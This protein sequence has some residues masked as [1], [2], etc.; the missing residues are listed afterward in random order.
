MI[1]S[2]DYPLM[3]V[4]QLARELNVPRDFVF[5]HVDE[6][7][8][9]CCVCGMPTRE[10]LAC[11]VDTS[12]SGVRVVRELARLT[13]ERATP[14]IIVSDNGTELTSSAVLRWVPG[15]VDVMINGKPI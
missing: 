3:T 7:G 8:A 2:E 1:N 13:N 15:R 14:D 5:A 10:C 12:P 6:L 4:G 9:I 11:V